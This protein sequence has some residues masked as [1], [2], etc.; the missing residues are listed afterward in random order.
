MTHSSNPVK[1]FRERLYISQ[2]KLAE[3]MGVSHSTLLRTEQG[4]YSEIPPVI[5][6]FLKANSEYTTTPIADYAR[7]RSEQ[8]ATSSQHLKPLGTTPFYLGQE[9]HPFKDWRERQGYRSR[10]SFCTAFCLHPSTLIRFEK[11]ISVRVPQDVVDLFRDF[12]LDSELLQHRY[13][14][15]RANN[16]GRS[17]P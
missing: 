9:E 11:G 3:E 1:E 13:T 16:V 7:F 5:L 10:L 6:R 4:L 15:W 12:N 2:E 14:S 8:R 17:T